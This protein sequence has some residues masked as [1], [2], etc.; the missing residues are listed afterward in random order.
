MS[1]HQADKNDTANQDRDA[2]PQGTIVMSEE[3][4]FFEKLLSM[5]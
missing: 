1:D 5:S 2:I 4:R 3:D